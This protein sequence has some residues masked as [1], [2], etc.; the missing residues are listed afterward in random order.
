MNLALQ[1][2]I[3]VG[4]LNLEL[5]LSPCLKSPSSL[6][7][8]LIFYCLPLLLSRLHYQVGLVS[9]ELHYS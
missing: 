4:S 1:I 5:P 7:L 2:C 6:D 8:S 3:E 9:M